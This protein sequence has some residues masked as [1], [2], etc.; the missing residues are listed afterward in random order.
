MTKVFRND[1][2]PPLDEDEDDDRDPNDVCQYCR[3]TIM[4]YLNDS[5]AYC[6][7]CDDEPYDDQPTEYGHWSDR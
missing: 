2:T 7:R 4:R 6:P 3:A 5:I 1:L